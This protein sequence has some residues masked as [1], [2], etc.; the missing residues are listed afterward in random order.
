MHRSWSLALAFLLA[1]VS[2][3]AGAAGE[4]PCQAIVAACQAAGFVPGGARQGDGLQRDC[5]EP[6]MAGTAQP[7]RAS[8]PLPSVDAQVVAACRARRPNAGA[9]RAAPPTAVPAPTAPLRAASGADGRPNI[10]FVLTDD[11]AV[12][13][14][15]YMPHVLK[16][17]RDGVTFA[18]YFVT[19]SLCCP[20]RSSI[21]TG[22]YPHNTGIFRNTG[23]DGGYAAF[24]NRGLD[25]ST[26]ATAL[27]AAGYRTA[28]LGKY[29]NG[30]GPRDPVPP[31]W[32]FW[33]V[34]GGGGYQEFRYKLNQNGTT[35]RHGDRPDDY[36]TDVLADLAVR[37]IRESG[38]APF[39]IEVATFAPHAPYI[40]ALRDAAALPALRAPQSA[41]LNAA[42]DAKTPPWLARLPALSD[43]DRSSIDRDFRM[44]AQSVLAIDKMIGELEAAVAATGRAKETY[45]IF[46]SDNGLHMGEH[47]MMPGKMTPYDIDIHVPLV[48]TGPG[49]PAGRVVDDVAENVDL[50]ATFTELGGA[51]MSSTVDGRSLVPFLRGERIADWRAA[52]LIEHRGPHRDPRDPDAPMARSG[53]PPSYEAM[54]M[55]RSLYVEYDDG[56]KEYHDLAADPDELKNTFGA[57]SAVEKASLAAALAAMKTCR[58]AESCALAERASRVAAR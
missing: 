1:A 35:V 52:A 47:R 49:V 50:C 55:R 28:M 33:A 6:I 8:R 14:L 3:G 32:S 19:D 20:S 17:Q 15:Q 11:L 21:F 30:Y 58:D 48:V 53:N 23:E 2:G 40:P 4:G 44:R 36:L 51:V 34:A 12:N 13:L 31:G 29:L 43:A 24:T 16:M 39:F 25:H 42:P 18:N 9:A 46:S 27:A 57:L 5:V 41:A 54:R 37:F 26:F 56:V 10:V 45:F 22:R 7:S 38:S